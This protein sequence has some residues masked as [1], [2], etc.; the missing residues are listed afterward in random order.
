MALN[1]GCYAG[2]GWGVRKQPEDK[3]WH[4]CHGYD[5]RRVADDSPRNCRITCMM[6]PPVGPSKLSYGTYTWID[7]DGVSRRYLRR[8]DGGGLTIVCLVVFP[9]VR[10]GVP[11]MCGRHRSHRRTGTLIS[12]PWMGKRISRHAR[13]RTHARRREFRVRPHASCYYPDLRTT[14]PQPIARVAAT[15]DNNLVKW[16]DELLFQKLRVSISPCLL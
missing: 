7:G 5:R 2:L 14:T 15:A 6:T 8:I 3:C 4:A 16:S 12:R 9:A 11:G 13:A 10:I 1:P